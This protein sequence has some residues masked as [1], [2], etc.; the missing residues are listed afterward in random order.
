MRSL[1]SF[2]PAKGQPHLPSC[3]VYEI[4]YVEDVG[5]F[6]ALNKYEL[7]SV[8]DYLYDH[9]V[10][11]PFSVWAGPLFSGSISFSGYSRFSYFSHLS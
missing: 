9:K 1:S 5:N 2:P 4:M 7:W 3:P 8:F 6:K 11:D 10:I